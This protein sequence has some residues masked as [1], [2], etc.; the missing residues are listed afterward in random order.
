[1]DDPNINMEEYIRLEEEKAHWR[2]KLYNWEIDTYGKIWYDEDVH[3]LRC[4][5]TEF[6]AIV[7]ND[8]LTFEVT[9]SCKPTISP[10][11]D[12]KIDLRTSFD[13]SDDDDYTIIYDEN[14]FS[15]KII[16]VNNLKTD[17]KN[18]DDKVNMPLFLSP[19]HEVS[20][21]NNLD[22]FKDFEKEFPAIP[23]IDA[24]TYKLDFLTEPTI[25]PQH[26]GESN[27]KDVT[28]LSETNEIR[29]ISALT[30]QGNAQTQFPIRRILPS[31]YAVSSMDKLQK[32]ENKVNNLALSVQHHTYRETTTDRILSAQ[33]EAR[34]EENFITEDLHGMINKLEPHVD[35]TLCLKN[36]SWIPCFGDLRGLIMHESH[37]SKYSIHLGSDKMYQDPKKLYW[38]PNMKA[39]IATYVSKCLTCAKVKEEYQKS[40]VLLVQPEIPQCNHRSPDQ[41][42]SFLT[43]EK[44]RLIGKVDKTRYLHNVLGTRLDM[45]TA[46]HPQTDGQSEM[47][48][49]TLKDI[50]K[51]AP[52]EALY[53]HNCRSPICW[54]EVGD[55]QLTGPKIIRDTTEKIVQI[56]SCIQVV[57][58]CEKSYVDVK[59]L[60]QSRI[61]IVKVRWNSRRGPEFTWEREYQMQKKYLHLFANHISASNATS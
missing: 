15:Y 25:S 54:A 58:N 12:H 31:T 59:H 7:L 38:W 28:S 23:Y 45:S 10:L 57:R 34:K 50:T 9:L 61:P 44:R 41:V 46:Y 53:G 56:K 49:Q 17:S 22:F 21:S 11:N 19:E 36:Q 26:V 27:L 2:G 43:Y 13:E 4:V 29:R 6:L 1:M 16:F 55:S 60:K 32:S 18:D 8:V 42:R 3:D 30:S 14:S 48:I 35:K 33:S 52:F 5:E 51:V 40:P 20:Y 37:K 39:E 47:T 24:L